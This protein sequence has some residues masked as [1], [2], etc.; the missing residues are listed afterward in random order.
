MVKILFS[1]LVVLIL[2]VVYVKYLEKKSVFFPDAKLKATPADAGLEYDDI[3]FETKDGVTLHGWL[4]KAAQNYQRA[5]TL[6]FL[7][8][9]AGNIGDRVE[10]IR[11]F[12]KLDVNVFIID[13]RGYG[14]SEGTPTEEGVYRDARDAFD[15]LRSRQDI[16]PD[17]VIVYGASLGGAVAIDLA[18]HR[19]V[20]ALIV[21]SSFT[22]AADMAKVIFPAAPAF[23]LSVK[24]DSEEKIKELDIPKLFFHSREDRVVPYLLGQRLYEAASE[25]KEFFDITGG[26]NDGYFESL[27]LIRKKMREF[28]QKHEVL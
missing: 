5:P 3:H 23:L 6:L 21:D 12:H 19:P 13:Y 9:N 26:H 10:K 11:F 24:W 8:G 14:R 15:Y 27:D 28:L 22:S 18:V 17:G 20:K 2:F 7:H 1:I 4:I 16:R 25:P